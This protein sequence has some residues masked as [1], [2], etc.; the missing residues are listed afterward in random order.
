V[1][2]LAI[3]LGLVVGLIVGAVGGGGAIL[4]LPVL[5]YFLDQPV[6][7][8]STASLIVVAL[9]AGVGAGS[10]ARH[11]H[12]CWRLAL[13]FSAPPLRGRCSGRSPATP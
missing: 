9:A 1:T 4:A 3:P 5:V 6:G 7:P 10:L 8:A 11:G 2:L 13:T 12:V